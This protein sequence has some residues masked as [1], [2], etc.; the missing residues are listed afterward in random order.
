MFYYLRSQIEGVSS[1]RAHNPIK[2]KTILA[3]YALI[4]CAIR[5]TGVVMFFAPTLG[6][7][8]L[9]RHLQG[10]QDLTVES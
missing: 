4:S 10:S 2:S 3:I 5:V 1:H 6:L 8:N 7:L 9:L